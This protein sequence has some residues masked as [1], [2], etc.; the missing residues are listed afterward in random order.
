MARP[1]VIFDFDGTLT[2]SIELALEIANALAP[3]FGFSPIQPAEVP[4]LRKMSARRLIS[5]FNIPLRKIPHFIR[6]VQSEY[7]L[8]IERAEPFPGMAETVRTLR[9]EGF[10]TAIMSS[11]KSATIFSFLQRHQLQKEFEFVYAESSLFGKGAALKRMLKERG[12]SSAEVI[13]VGD[14]T[15]DRDACEAAGIRFVGVAWGFNSPETL[16]EGV[17][18]PI[19][20]TPSELVML[21]SATVLR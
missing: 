5:H 4:R 14:E 18:P 20:Y 13:Y 8:R 19:A 10:G 11:N 17:C 3:E 6:R 9:L 2:S 12:L 16:S 1:T 7:A 15:R 21:I